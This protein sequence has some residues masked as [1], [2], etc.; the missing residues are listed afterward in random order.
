VSDDDLAAGLQVIQLS[1]V[2]MNPYVRLLHES[3][4]RLGVDSSISEGLSPRLVEFWRNQV[5]VLH[6]HWLELFYVRPRVRRTIRLSAAVLSA[7]LLAKLWGLRIVSTVHN[8]EA[9]EQLH[10]LLEGVGSSLLM[11]LS[12]G[13]HVHDHAAAQALSLRGV[14]LGKVHVIP[15]GSYIGAY[16]NTSDRTEARR[17]L[18]LPVDGF[19][20]LFLGQI[21]PYKGI[22]DLVTAFEALNDEGTW[23]VI[24]G[25]VHEPEYGAWLRELCLGNARIQTHLQYVPDDQLQYFWAAAD[26]GVL[27]YRK[28]TTSGAAVLA[29]SFGRPF[30]APALAGFP[31]L[32]QQGKGILYD[33]SEADGLLEA[34][35]RTRQADVQALSSLA[36]AW[37]EAHRWD[38]VAPQFVSMYGDVIGNGRQRI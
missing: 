28:V 32:A 38:V 6:V 31:E 2:R 26:V 4:C 30:V 14:P 18:R 16:P 24:A 13:L 36:L 8:L 21:R 9:H 15:H 10:P 1:R 33:P 22:E 5:D 25:N 35:R 7:L 23:L 3:L 29:L 12:D 20:F 37:A 19:V 27:P 17:H 34:L 11:H